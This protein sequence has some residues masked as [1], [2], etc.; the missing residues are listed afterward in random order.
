MIQ[1]RRIKST[2]LNINSRGLK[3]PRWRWVAIGVCGALLLFVFLSGPEGTVRLAKMMWER[4]RLTRELIDLDKENDSIQKS[5]ER[6]RRDPAAVEEEA[7]EKLGFVKKGEVI[8][9]FTKKGK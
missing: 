4:K 9:R 2:R 5:I 7:R 6:F 1:R 8:Y 3:M